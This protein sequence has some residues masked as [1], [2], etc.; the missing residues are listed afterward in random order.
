[1]AGYRKRLLATAS[2]IALALALTACGSDDDGDGDGD[3]DGGEEGGAAEPVGEPFILGTTDTVTALDPAGS[4]DLG[5]SALEYN[6]YQTLVTVPPGSNE[7]VGDAA[8]SCEYDDPQTLTC[9]LKDGL[10]F[11]NGDPLTSSDVLYSFERSLRIADPIGAAIYLLGSISTAN[12]D[13]TYELTEGAIETPDDTTVIFHL[14]KPDA[15]FQYVLTYPGAGAIVNEDVYPPDAKLPDEEVIGSGPYKLS[16]Y[17]AGEQ[18]VFELNENYTGD[19]VGQAP[20]VFVSYFQEP[21]TMKLALE[22]EEIDIAWRSLG[23]TDINDLSGNSA[24]TVA[25]GTGG[26]I[27]YWVFN[28]DAGVTKQPAVRQAAA[29]LFDRD[30]I[31]EN[32]YDGTVDPLFSS[33]PPGLAGQ[34]DAFADAYGEPNVAAAKQILDDAGISTP[35]DLTVGYSPTHYG[36]NAVD[37]ATEL[38]RQLNESGLFNVTLESA[39]WEQYQTISKEGAYDL[40][41][42][43][44]FPDFPDADTYLTPFMSVDNFYQNGYSSERA[45][46][47]LADEQGESDPAAREKIITQLQELQ[48]E[49]VPF[50]PSWVGPNIAVYGEGVEGVEETLDPSFIFR[51]W[52]VT[53]NA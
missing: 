29:Q 47:L 6:L 52:L 13:G 10:T 27:R 41:H 8:E 5:S 26:E 35:V 7:I 40:W 37:E 11:S 42:L 20:Q 53:K 24:V 15:V 3:G 39:E 45:N 32:A 25:Q 21:G 50:I 23:P 9:T 44:W 12:D 31:A 4:Y 28:T 43:G 22:N 46:Q 48:A 1:M 18:A 2:A 49:D 38:Q 17:T 33:V 51:F 36:P 16:S 14:N 34:V 19:N 30:A